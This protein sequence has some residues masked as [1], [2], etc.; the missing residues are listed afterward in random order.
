VPSHESS[1]EAHSLHGHAAQPA[2]DGLPAEAFPRAAVRDLVGGNLLSARRRELAQDWAITLGLALLA[3]ALP[4]ERLLGEGPGAVQW[5]EHGHWFGTHLVLQPIAQGLS[6]ISGVGAERAWYLI[7]ALCWAGSYPV[8]ARMNVALGLSR[9]AACVG[10]LLC[11]V[12]PVALLAA[13][14]PGPAGPALFGSALLFA[15]LITGAGSSERAGPL[16]PIAAWGAACLLDTNLILLLPA[17]LW[18][19]LANTRERPADRR[20]AL[21]AVAGAIV[22]LCGAWVAGASLLQGAAPAATL[23]GIG[24]RLLGTGN[25]GSPDGVIWLLVLAPALGVGALGIVELFRRPTEAHDASPPGWIAAYVCI[26][27]VVKV[28]GGAPNLDTGAWVLA[29]LTA[30]GLASF[31][32]RMP[33]GR[34]SGIILGLGAAQLLL[35]VGFRAALGLGDP[36]REWMTRASKMLE[37][38]DI[39]ITRD[40]LHDYLLR[41]RFHLA[42]VN[43]RIPL[44]LS[45][46]RRRDWWANV[47]EVVRAHG[48]GGG[49]VLL[50]WRVGDPLAGSRD[51]PYHA[52]L[53]ELILLAPALHLDPQGERRESVSDIAVPTTFEP[54]K[55][56]LPPSLKRP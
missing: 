15:T 52:E 48:R 42:T 2:A 4:T 7:A 54:E 18:H 20:R 5:T 45:D 51:Y 53:H 44:E 12:S 22:F 17:V 37:R 35:S 23:R 6:R 29:P 46:R 43:L 38:G 41:H 34:R 11:L 16:R 26:P 47:R 3:L 36:N 8:L 55:G 14:L 32:E 39:V 9:L 13:T 56:N 21:A 1:T 24:L 27:I 33:D 49:R 31:V 25:V 19:T 50:D 28:L 40:Q 30:L 10:A